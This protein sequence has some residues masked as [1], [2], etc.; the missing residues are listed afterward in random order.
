MSFTQELQSYG[1]W[2]LVLSNPSHSRVR[3]LR[4]WSTLY[5]IPTDVPDIENYTQTEV[6]QM[7]MYAGVLL[8]KHS[9]NGGASLTISGHDL[10]WWLGEPFREGILCPVD[11]EFMDAAPCD[12][13]TEL[14]TDEIPIQ[15]GECTNPPDTVPNHLFTGVIPAGATIVEALNR[16]AS[17]TY[18]TWKVNPNGTVD[19]GTADDLFNTEFPY[20]FTSDP[21]YRTTRRGERPDTLNTYTNGRALN[22]AVV[23]TP[24]GDCAGSIADIF[25]GYKNYSYDRQAVVSTNAGTEAE[26]VTLLNRLVNNKARLQIGADATFTNRPF[27]VPRINTGDTVLVHD[28]AIGWT[29]ND[30]TERVSLGAA[31]RAQALVC[32]TKTWAFTDGMTACL[33]N[34]DSANP[35]NITNWLNKERENT[36]F[37]MGDRANTFIHNV[38]GSENAVTPIEDIFDAS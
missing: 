30:D 8:D 28:D 15:L 36:R 10:A 26:A 16:V 29:S 13:L 4:M 3:V 33:V 5:I 17:E 37:V 31:L 27:L 2:S 38:L 12:V 6:E 34:P 20:V 32:S 35:W 22:G 19:F 23:E 18:T 25:V 9:T 14:W 24:E 11:R 21:T 1:R 7:A